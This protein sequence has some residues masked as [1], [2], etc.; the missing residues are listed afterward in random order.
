MKTRK[1]LLV[2][3]C[4]VLLVVYYL[5]GTDYLKQQQEREVLASQIAEAT[6]ALAQIPAPPADLE[7][8]LAAAQTSLEGIR[9]SFPSK[10]NSTRII[11]TILKLADEVG[12]K[13]I[14]LITQPWA[15]ESVSDYDY[16][17]FRLNI[18][19][20]GTFAQLVSFLNQLENG[21]LET[22]IVENFRVSRVTESSGAESTPG[23]NTQ[24][25]A[26]LDIAIHSQS[27][28]IDQ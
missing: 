15:I 25:N 7:E 22:L 13:A 14:P 12:V 24:V 18:A 10:L 1:L 21:E 26:S 23:D 9:N 27:P 20:T 4:A 6:Q 17:V 2:L 5:M 19:V 3:L 11:N 16:F 28:T 8:Q